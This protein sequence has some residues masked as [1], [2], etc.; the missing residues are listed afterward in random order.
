MLGRLLSR[1]DE[2]LSSGFTTPSM[3]CFK[4]LGLYA[5]TANQQKYPGVASSNH[6]LVHESIC[7]LP[8]KYHSSVRIVLQVIIVP[9]GMGEGG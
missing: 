6:S 1:I 8:H 7:R 5:C 9:P 2:R 3:P 4:Q